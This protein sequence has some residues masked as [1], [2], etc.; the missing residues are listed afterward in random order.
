MKLSVWFVGRGGDENNAVSWGKT[1]RCGDKIKG[2]KRD[3]TRDSDQ[4][5]IGGAMRQKESMTGPTWG[6]SVSFL[7]R[8]SFL[9]FKGIPR[10]FFSYSSG[11]SLGMAQTGALATT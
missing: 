3:T 11:R 1:W 6:V 2:E 10:T 4:G 5:R 9:T 7:L 8:P